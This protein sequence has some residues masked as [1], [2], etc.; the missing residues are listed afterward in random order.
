VE[1]IPPDPFVRKTI[2]SC[3]QHKPGYVGIEAEQF[4]E[5]LADDL[6][7]G[8][9]EGT[10]W[11]V[12]SMTTEAVARIR[13]PTWGREARRA[14]EVELLWIIALRRGIREEKKR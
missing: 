10:S 9:R 5:L 11:P 14:N 4:R 12:H 3:D 1:R 8:G 2:V 13:I 6:H 7:R